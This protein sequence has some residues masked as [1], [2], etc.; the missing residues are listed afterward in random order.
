MRR[1]SRGGGVRTFLIGALALLAGAVMPA[2]VWSAELIMIEEPGCPWCRAWNEQIGIA[3]P[4]TDEGRRAPLRRVDLTEPWPEDLKDIRPER[5][6]PLLFWWM[7]ARK[8][9]VCAAIPGRTSSGRFWMRCWTSSIWGRTREGKR[10][11]VTFVCWQSGVWAICL[12]S[13]QSF[14][15]VM[16]VR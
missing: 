16:S 10:R 9:P 13:N 15:K 4:H 14:M 7:R 12:L 1:N 5:V 6:T 11:C 3:Y 2:G 8:W